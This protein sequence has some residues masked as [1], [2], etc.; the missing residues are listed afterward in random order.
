MSLSF[1]D[2]GVIR[3]NRDAGDDHRVTP[4]TP[5][6]SSNS[7]FEP[8]GLLSDVRRCHLAGVGGGRALLAP[9]SEAISADDENALTAEAIEALLAEFEDEEF[10]VALEA[11]AD[12]AAARHCAPSAP[13]RRSRRRRARRNRRRAVG[14]V[15]RYGGG[16]RAR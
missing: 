4:S 8:A 7:P 13:G 12:E 3:Q 11:L 10:E 9:F 5:N 6:A 14:R 1:S 15:H 16:P 2:I